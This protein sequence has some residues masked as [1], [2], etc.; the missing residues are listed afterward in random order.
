MAKYP[1]NCCKSCGSSTP[2]R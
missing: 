1:F 2:A